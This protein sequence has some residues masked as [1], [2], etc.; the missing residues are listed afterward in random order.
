MT[1]WPTSCTSA[2]TRT[3]HETEDKTKNKTSPGNQ[4][5]SGETCWAHACAKPAKNKANAS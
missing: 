2:G 3:R 4:P 1:P 5:L